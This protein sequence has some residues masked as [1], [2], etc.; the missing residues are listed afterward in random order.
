MFLVLPPPRLS[1]LQRTKTKTMS[2]TLST[3]TCCRSAV[4]GT[5]LKLQHLVRVSLLLATSTTT[6]KSSADS[7]SISLILGNAGVLVSAMQVM[8]KKKISTSGM[9]TTPASTHQKVL[10]KSTSGGTT[11][12]S[13]A[14]FRS[15]TTKSKHFVAQ[16]DEDTSETTSR[17]SIKI[18][19]RGAGGAGGSLLQRTSTTTSKSLLKLHAKTRG[20]HQNS[21]NLLSS[22]DV[23]H[24]SLL[25][26]DEVSGAATALPSNS[27]RGHR[28]ITLGDR[29]I[30]NGVE[31]IMTNGTK[32]DHEND[33]DRTSSATT[34]LEQQQK[35]KEKQKLQWHYKYNVKCERTVGK[36][37]PQAPQEIQAYATVD[38]G[39]LSPESE[40]SLY[41]NRTVSRYIDDQVGFRDEGGPIGR[42][43]VVVPSLY[44]DNVKPRTE[45]LCSEFATEFEDL[46]GQTE[47]G[48]LVD[49]KEEQ[50]QRFHVLVPFF[51]A[52]ADVVDT[53]QFKWAGAEGNA[54]TSNAEALKGHVKSSSGQT[55]FEVFDVLIGRLLGRVEKQLVLTGRGKGCDF[56]QRWMLVSNIPVEFF[57]KYRAQV[58][59]GQC[60]TYGYLDRYRP[61]GEWKTSNCRGT[62]A[63]KATCDKPSEGQWISSEDHWKTHVVLPP[64]LDDCTSQ[65]GYGSRSDF[66]PML[67]NHE[68]AAQEAAYPPALGIEFDTG[69]NHWLP[70]N[71]PA[72]PQAPL[73]L[74]LPD[75][76]VPVT[77]IHIETL[78]EVLRPVVK[79]T[80]G[81]QAGQAL[82]AFPPFMQKVEA[83]I[84]DADTDSIDNY[85]KDTDRSGDYV[86][87]NYL[88]EHVFRRFQVHLTLDR[89]DRCLSLSHGN[90]N[91]AVRE[92][93]EASAE[94]QSA[95]GCRLKYA[96]KEWFFEE[97]FCEFG[98]AARFY[99]TKIEA[100]QRANAQGFHRYQR[101]NSWRFW[102]E[103][104]LD[105][106]NLR[107]KAE[108]D[109]AFDVVENDDYYYKFYDCE[110]LLDGYVV[111]DPE[112]NCRHTWTFMKQLLRSMLVHED[113]A[114]IPAPPSAD[115]ARI[116][117]AY[118]LI[119]TT[120]PPPPLDCVN[121]A[122]EG[123]GPGW[124]SQ[125]NE[126]TRQSECVENHC[127][128]SYGEPLQSATRCPEDGVTPGCKNGGCWS[129]FRSLVDE[130]ATKNSTVVDDNGETP[131]VLL[132]ALNQC[133][134]EFGLPLEH[135]ALCP[136]HGV[137]PGCWPESKFCHKGYKIEGVPDGNA[138][139][140]E[141]TCE[142]PGTHKEVASKECVANYCK[143]FNGV[144]LQSAEFCPENLSTPGCEPGQC[145]QGSHE[146]TEPN[147]PGNTNKVCQLNHC[148][149][150]FGADLI[151]WPCPKNGEPGCEADKCNPGYV[152]EPD[153]VVCVSSTTSTTTTSTTTVNRNEQVFLNQEKPTKVI[154]KTAFLNLLTSGVARKG[155]TFCTEEDV[156][157][158]NPSAQHSY[159]PDYLYDE[160]HYPDASGKLQT[161]EKKT[162][163]GKTY[164]FE[165][166]GILYDGEVKT[167]LLHLEDLTDANLKANRF[168]NCGHFMEHCGKYENEDIPQASW[169]DCG[170]NMAK[171]GGFQHA[172]HGT[173]NSTAGDENVDLENDLPEEEEDGG[174]VVPSEFDKI[175]KYETPWAVVCFEN[176]SPFKPHWVI[177]PV[178]VFTEIW[179]KSKMFFTS[180]Y[181]KTTFVS[182]TNNYNFRAAEDDGEEAEKLY[183]LLTWSS[184][185]TST[186]NEEEEQAVVAGSST[187]DGQEA[188]EEQTDPPPPADA[189]FPPSYAPMVLWVGK[190]ATTLYVKNALSPGTAQSADWVD[191]P[192]GPDRD[193][194]GNPAVYLNVEKPSKEGWE[195][196]FASREAP[197]GLQWCGA[198]LS[199]VDQVK[200]P[201]S[202]DCTPEDLIVPSRWPYYF[203]E[204]KATLSIEAR[205]LIQD[206]EAESHPVSDKKEPYCFEKG[207]V[208]YNN[209][210]RDLLAIDTLTDE[211]LKKN[212]LTNCARW[213]TGKNDNSNPDEYPADQPFMLVSAPGGFGKNMPALF[214]DSV[215]PWAVVCFENQYPS[216]PKTVLSD[217]LFFLTFT[218]PKGLLAENG[219]DN[220][221]LHAPELLEL[222]FA[223]DKYPGL[224]LWV[225]KAH[226][227]VFFKNSFTKATETSIGELIT[228]AE[229]KA[230][231]SLTPKDDGAVATEAPATTAP[232]GC[233]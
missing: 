218:N 99:S 157:T 129:G 199:M 125:V 31:E 94:V 136:E 232:P 105:L 229:P 170:K 9:K 225:G 102:L 226:K 11:A 86:V 147:D 2:T 77:P 212:D 40:Q 43:L 155:L 110:T 164:C 36:F 189:G 103:W 179:K 20:Q 108:T 210:V 28:P 12:S 16:E 196:A 206:V 83:K 181:P 47:D 148:D 227:T 35:L 145:D 8:D 67:V 23:G 61:N 182:T 158:F 173:S 128:C 151:G 116:A 177:T 58:L 163:P 117:A 70:T 33:Q 41:W 111:N 42:L 118:T 18:S 75:R 27:T 224:M 63:L 78:E 72:E 81:D 202:P 48:E 152:L 55:A 46:N 115:V 104:R 230:Q 50:Y 175:R 51:A 84:S 124:K 106:Q 6:W 188:G 215:F 174:G 214:K 126:E 37:V 54:D 222:L 205:A 167:G 141:N 60:D 25:L 90:Q 32:Y 76:V 112:K 87:T 192:A 7:I 133:Y 213:M 79:D 82:P 71:T 193:R 96:S 156:A 59:L 1:Q 228:T 64:E 68:G 130:A 121:L 165:Q 168:E 187:T 137:T 178:E 183:R 172:G 45:D 208:L 154:D 207:G 159:W 149:C 195:E 162:G 143:C 19:G 65:M 88:H 74:A 217:K 5:Q 89:G 198:G 38:Q 26:L 10:Q 223:T 4:R 132:C 24:N 113:D 138:I 184:S 109:L 95:D 44:S 85:L 134:C 30:F 69:F 98:S 139:C 73:W 131:E 21:R 186:S 209:E 219:E 91:A 120:T 66:Y 101:A 153:S 93:Y 140:V 201:P 34:F 142:E 122:S 135:S 221:Q 62:D 176:K 166:G 49:G 194:F 123:Y 127:R 107:E 231:E 146:I 197:G 80:D 169:A 92:A 160:I 144:P 13:A 211:N 14:S 216:S 233:C 15:K 56:L 53:S 180:E 52:A 161:L 203:S 39:L 22:E 200:H 150:A 57:N 185:S 3:S 114:A 17:K 29:Q 119:H 220:F 191:C 171:A 100:R 204:T 97:H 190:G